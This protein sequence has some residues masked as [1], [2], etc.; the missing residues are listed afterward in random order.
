M[1][2]ADRIR[3]MSDEEL[4]MYIKELMFNDFKPAC[5]K[6]AF[7]RQSINQSATKIV[8][9]ACCTGSSNRRRTPDGH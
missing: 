5:K 2:N 8:R 1:T 4:A 6:S 3:S 7:F 9:R